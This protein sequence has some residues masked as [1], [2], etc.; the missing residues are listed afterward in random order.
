MTHLN[1]LTK[2]LEPPTD[3]N[4]KLRQ[5]V[6]EACQH[7]PGSPQRQRRLTQVIRLV[8]PKLW[9]ES[10]ADY[11]DAVQQTWVY[12]CKNICLTYDPTLGSVPTW[13]NAYL[14]RRLQDFYLNTQTR[15]Q[16]EISSWQDRDGEVVDV[17]DTVADRDRS[18]LDA[19]I[20]LWEK[21]REWAETNPELQRIHIEGHPEITA[22][23]LILRR[24]LSE[25]KWKDLAEE[26]GVK[27][28]TLS[29]F[30]QRQCMTRLRNFGEAE[31]YM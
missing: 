11:A 17:I 8:S 26:F 13:L 24:L 31:G 9:R 27:V 4:S 20:P 6:T 3:L 10:V 5:L 7:P 16:R 12:F 15:R 19:E 1:E 14:K 30:Y 2:P 18:I 22:Q 29:A 25:T 21:V 23:V 28:P